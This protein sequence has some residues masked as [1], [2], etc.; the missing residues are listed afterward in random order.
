MSL[1]H[2]LLTALIE[3]PA[4]GLDLAKRFDRSIGYFWSATHQQIYKELGRMES[5]GLIESTPEENARGVKKIHRVLGKGRQELKRWVAECGEPA[6]LRD[7]LMV[8]LRAEGAIGPA[9]LAKSLQALR[10]EHVAK[11]A[12][13]QEFEARDFSKAPS[14]RAAALRHV[15]LKAGLKHENYW[16]EVLD[17]ALSVLAQDDD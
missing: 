6:P 10:E 1:R 7:P 11:R 15:V 13:Y 14:D 9:G 3:K 4:S 12:L 2:A 5:D 8:R 17:E 16:I